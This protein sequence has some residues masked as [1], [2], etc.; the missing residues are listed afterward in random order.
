MNKVCS[1]CNEVKPLEDFHKRTAAKDGRQSVCKDCNK[2]QRK[3]Y[4][5]TARGR[6]K[7]ILTGKQNKFKLQSQVIEYLQKN[8]CVDCG[9]SDIVVLEFDHIRDKKYNISHMVRSGMAWSKVQEEISKCEV[10]CANCHRR[11]TAQQFG[12]LKSTF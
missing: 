9:E 4:Y 7:N 6:A 1:T 5:K 8:S 3:A 11:R 10:R 12:W 2:S